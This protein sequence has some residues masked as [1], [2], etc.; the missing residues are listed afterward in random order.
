MQVNNFIKY[1]EQPLSAS[2]APDND[3]NLFLKKFP[4]CQSGQLMLAIQL[5]RKNSILFD[6]QLK[7]AAAYC[8]DRNQLFNQLQYEQQ[9]GEELVVEKVRAK[10]KVKFIVEEEAII[11]TIKEV[12]TKGLDTLEKEYLS[13]AVS[14]SIL[15]EAEEIDITKPR[16]KGASELEREV[17]L[18]DKNKGHSFSSWLKHYN[19]EDA[20]EENNDELELNK[21]IKQDLI[22]RFIQE[23]PLF[24]T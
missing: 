16:N 2:E 1:L 17:V 20:V 9:E 13:A 23:D 8:T 5:K 7:T 21:E 12:D 11:E 22:D 19:G 24:N 3:V 6:Q 4:Y 18:F 10:E 14:S 15:L